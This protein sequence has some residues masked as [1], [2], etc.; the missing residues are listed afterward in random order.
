MMLGWVPEEVYTQKILSKSI[1]IVTSGETIVSHRWHT[2]WKHSISS[3]EYLSRTEEVT[4]DLL[5]KK[6]RR[7]P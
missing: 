4:D 5:P 6:L 1:Y 2:R 7:P 3:R